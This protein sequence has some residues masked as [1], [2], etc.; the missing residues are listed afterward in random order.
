ML[1]ICRNKLKMFANV[2]QNYDLLLKAFCQAFNE[3]F[4]TVNALIWIPVINMYLRS[5]HLNPDN[6]QLGSQWETE[7]WQYSLCVL[8]LFI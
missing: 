3:K 8:P 4:C 2:T 7:M 1:L 6:I 5:G